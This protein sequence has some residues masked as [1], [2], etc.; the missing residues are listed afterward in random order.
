MNDRSARIASILESK[1]VR[2]TVRVVLAVTVFA[3]GMISA[4]DLGVSGGSGATPEYINSV[5]QPAYGDTDAILSLQ[6]EIPGQ[7]RPFHRCTATLIAPDRAVTAAH[8]VDPPPPAQDEERAAEQDLCGSNNPHNDPE[9]GSTS[10][11]TLTVRGGSKNYLGGGE[12]AT[13]VGQAVS[14]GWTWELTDGAPRHDVAVLSLDPPMTMNPIPL[15]TEVPEAG[16]SVV[17]LG[18]STRADRCGDII[19]TVQQW[20][21]EMESCPNSLT[22]TEFEVCTTTHGAVGP[23]QGVSGGP[24]LV[25]TDGRPSAILGVYTVQYGDYCG[26][27]YQGYS[28]L[29]RYRDFLDDQMIE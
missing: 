1:P 3:L 22:L 6:M 16:R 11:T 14:P 18:W 19:P 15:A 23:C 8:C 5:V 13:V 2:Y 28:N 17:S 26:Q 29:L 21:M 10:Q 24:L 27:S 20:T 9:G 25:I 7:D 4:T 12:T